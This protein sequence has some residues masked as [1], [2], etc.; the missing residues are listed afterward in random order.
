MRGTPRLASS[1]P[2]RVSAFVGAI[3]LLLGLMSALA[4]SPASAHVE[5]PSYWPDPKPD[6]TVDPCAGGE[7][8]QIRTLASALDVSKP[9]DTRIVCQPDSLDRVKASI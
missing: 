1:R 3:G 2:R 9:G 5:R 7:V 6:C 8:P 4:A